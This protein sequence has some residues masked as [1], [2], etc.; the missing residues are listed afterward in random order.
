MKQE[1]FL[2][3][4][5]TTW[6]PD[7]YAPK[8]IT[9]TLHQNRIYGNTTDA[10]NDTA[11]TYIADFT[12]NWWGDI[13]PSNNV[14]GGGIDYAPWYIDA[15]MT[16]LIPV[17]NVT[18]DTYYI[19]IQAAINAASPG[20]TINVAAGTYTETGQ[21]MIDKNLSIVGADKATTDRKARFSIRE[22]D[23][24]DAG[25]WILVD[26]EITFDLSKVTRDGAGRDIRQAIRHKGSGMWTM[27]RSIQNMVY[28]RLYGFG[29][30]PGMTSTTAMSLTVTNSTFTNFGRVGI[31]IDEGSGTSNV[32][33][34]PSLEILHLSVRA[35]GDQVCDYAIQSGGG[36]SGHA[37]V[38]TQYP[39]GAT[40][41]GFQV[42]GSK[43][44]L[45]I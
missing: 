6:D 12:S 23:S 34:R 45:M 27:S 22:T 15:G 32:P 30:R 24:G 37:S 13:D 33:S 38:R 35:T 39:Y 19:T 42:D 28:T 14:I 16:T 41:C 4:N 21:I 40:K 10:E 31:L 36:H 1:F 29:Y 11:G 43:T 25:S 5:E 18:Q 2:T 17:H 20:D 7:P 8:T 44:L 9:A 3:A 26:D